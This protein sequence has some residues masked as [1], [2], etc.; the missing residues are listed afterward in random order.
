MSAESTRER[1]MAQLSLRDREHFRTGYRVPALE[2]GLVEM[3]LPDKPTSRLQKYRLTEAGRQ[4][5]AM[6]QPGCSE[7]DAKKGPTP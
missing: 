3:A 1:L 7:Q 4:M 2:A 5:Q 6:L